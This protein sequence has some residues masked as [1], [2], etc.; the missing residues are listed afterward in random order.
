MDKDRVL[1]WFTFLL[2][3]NMTDDSH[4]QCMEFEPGY[5]DAYDALMALSE[6]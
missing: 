4:R 6:D 2:K 5:A 3:Y 1:M